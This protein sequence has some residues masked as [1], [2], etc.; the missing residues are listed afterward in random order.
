MSLRYEQYRALI[1]ARDFLRA[2]LDPKQTPRVPRRVRAEACRCLR[3]YPFLDE[4]GAPM[5]SNDT[6]SPP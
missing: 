6:L 4:H 5:F 3:H 1:Y 2:L